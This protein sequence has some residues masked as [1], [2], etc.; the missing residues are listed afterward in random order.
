MKFICW[1]IIIKVLKELICDGVVYV[2]LIN[3]LNK[4]I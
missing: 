4:K 2:L 3:A 1:N